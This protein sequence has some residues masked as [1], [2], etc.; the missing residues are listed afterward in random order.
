M[1][2]LKKI[3]LVG[4]GT[5]GEKALQF[6][7]EQRVL[8]FA[9]THHYDRVYCGKQVVSFEELKSIHKE[10]QVILTVGRQYIDE[11][12]CQLNE[13]GIPFIR[14]M[15]QLDRYRHDLY[16]DKRIAAFKNIHLN[17][18]CFLIGNGPS[19]LATDLDKLQA[20]GYMSI[21]CNFINRI[22]EKTGWRPDYYCCEES[23]AM[24][25]NRDFIMN[26]PMK[27]KFI[28]SPRTKSEAELFSGAPDDVHFFFQGPAKL[29]VSN[30]IAG[31]I[32]DGHT[33]MFPMLQIAMYMGFSEIYL[34]GVDNSQPPGPHTSNFIEAQSH[35]YDEDLDELEKRR[36][37]LTP[38]GYDDDWERYFSL[39]NS[40]YQVIREYAFEKGIGVYNATRGG[41]LEVFERVDIDELLA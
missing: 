20:R 2:K 12:S 35:F 25:L 32:Y 19:L 38:Y 33:V 27:A 13:A 17:K 18:K 21:A 30:N 10:H 8:C 22:F 40:H 9:D 29:T 11:L 6:F 4:A 39:V 41:Q 24:A 26:Y 1:E 31:I 5:Y 28:K 16:E 37:I 23:S 34:L 36:E 14:Y 7:G 3:I 15:D